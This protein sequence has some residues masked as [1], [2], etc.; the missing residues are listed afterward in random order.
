MDRPRNVVFARATT[1]G[2]GL[3]VGG[4]AQ[5]VSQEIVVHPTSIENKRNRSSWH[6]TQAF[7]ANVSTE[8][9]AQTVSDHLVAAVKDDRRPALLLAYGRSGSGKTT[10]LKAIV[11]TLVTALYKELK[12]DCILR[13]NM[14]GVEFHLSKVYDL[15][16]VTRTEL[17]FR[18]SGHPPAGRCTTDSC[19]SFQALFNKML[20]HA[21]TATTENNMHSSRSHTFFNLDFQVDLGHG[22]WESLGNLG[23]LDL[24]G[25]EGVTAIPSTSSLA[26][27]RAYKVRKQEGNSIRME[28]LEVQKL[29]SDYAKMSNSKM[30]LKDDKY[31]LYRKMPVT[32]AM[33]PFLDGK[34]SII[35][36][37]TVSLWKA[38]EGR[39]SDILNFGRSLGRICALWTEEDR[40]QGARVEVAPMTPTPKLANEQ[41]I[42][43][44]PVPVEMQDSDTANAVPLD[45]TATPDDSL[46]QALALVKPSAEVRSTVNRIALL[47]FGIGR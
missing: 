39:Q 9:V 42:R 19:D 12:V 47:D 45:V 38:S 35:G 4:A 2:R 7:D 46:E 20:Q 11:F 21:S 26:E 10:T 17:P 29:L 24:A 33:L 15:S 16:E 36:L 14:D 25:S 43:T 40:E 31:R 30:A 27:L 1:F 22:R 37:I 3:D 34:A 28:L 5:P 13:I 23:I 18:P 6:F 44:T 32:R 41:G 8:D